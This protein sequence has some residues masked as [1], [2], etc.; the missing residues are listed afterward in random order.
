M[1]SGLTRVGYP[2][3]GD[4]PGDARLTTLMVTSTNGVLIVMVM[5]YVY[6]K[7]C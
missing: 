7:A 5:R 2:S 6:I 1:S 4:T 3:D